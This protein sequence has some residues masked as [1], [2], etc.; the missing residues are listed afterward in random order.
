MGASAPL[1]LI[2]L[3]NK[4]GHQ[5]S[6]ADRPDRRSAHGVLGDSRHWAIE[7][8]AISDHFDDIEYRLS[9]DRANDRKQDLR[10][11]AVATIENCESHPHSFSPAASRAARAVLYCRVAW[12]I[13]ADT[14]ISKI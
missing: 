2:R 7:L 8:S 5:F 1:A 3:R 10:P 13:A 14:T 11:Q 9:R 6:V 12:P 4:R